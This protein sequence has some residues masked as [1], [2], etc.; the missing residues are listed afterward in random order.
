MQHRQLAVC[1]NEECK[2]EWTLQKDLDEYRDGP[3]C[4][5]CGTRDVGIP[6]QREGTD[7]PA[8]RVFTALKEGRSPVEIVATEGLDPKIVEELAEQFERLS[9]YQILSES[10][11]EQ[12]KQEG[13]KKGMTPGR[14]WGMSRAS[15]TERSGVWVVQG[16]N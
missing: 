10:G 11:I 5:N 3:R 14:R 16:M 4:P 8:S 13:S 7:S 2:E 9:D 6:G 15:R 1:G 12:V